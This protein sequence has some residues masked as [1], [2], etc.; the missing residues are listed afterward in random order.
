MRRLPPLQT[1]HA[2]ES[3]ARHSS[4]LRAASELHVTASAIS[5]R[6]RALEKF[7]G[8]ALFRRD[9]R[10]VRL[11]SEGESYL[12]AVREGLALI[13][14]A[15]ERLHVPRPGGVLTLSVAPSFATPW[16]APRLAGF[17]LQHPELEVRQTTSIELVDFAKSDVDAAVRYGGGRWPGVCAHRLFAEELVPVASPQY[18]IGR[19]RLRK[20]EDL[21]QATLLHVMFR[22]GEWRVWLK[23]AGV[24]GIDDQ[25]GPKFHTTPL[26]LEA[27][28]AGHGVAI[29]DRALIADHLKSKRLVAPFDIALPSEYAYYL[30]YPEDRKDNPNIVVFK[31]WLL[32]EAARP[33]EA[34]SRDFG[35]GQSN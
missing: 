32:A 35:T 30:V 15:T 26:A 25:R 7:L 13:A 11:T 6:I 20:P 5:H 23:A 21:R 17:Q 16:L 27:A 9:G 12:R 19:G 2:F 1:L 28:I 29:A 31:E 22:L 33:G 8:V 3:A 34:G 4:F 24:T 14:A 18:R 10:Q